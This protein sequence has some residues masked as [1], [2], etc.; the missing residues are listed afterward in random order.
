MDVDLEQLL[1]IEQ[2]AFEQRLALEFQ[3]LS[4]ALE[5]SSSSDL[6]RSNLD[7]MLSEVVFDH[8]LFVKVCNLEAHFVNK[9][10]EHIEFFGGN[11]TGVEV[12]R[13]T[14][15]DRDKLFHDVLGVDEN[16]LRDRLYALRDAHGRH[17]INQEWQVTKDVFNIA[18]LWLIHG[19]IRSSSLDAKLRYEAQIRLGCY[20]YYKFLTSLLAHYFKY[21]ADRQVAQATYESLTLKFALKQFGSWWQTIRDLSEKTLGSESPYR[22]DLERMDDD[23]RVLYIIA[24]LQGRIRDMLKNIYKEFLRVHSSG[25]KIVSTSALVESD[26]EMVLRDNTKN[27]GVYAR[28][29]KSIIADKNTFIRPEL[30]DV[31]AS[32]MHTLSRRL[33]QQSLEWTSDNYL[34]QQSRQIEEAVDIVLEH[35]IEYMSLNRTVQRADLANLI[36]KLRGAYMSSR[37]TDP[38]LILA[39]QA[40]GELVK[41]ATGSRNESMVATVRTSWM[42]YVVS[43][44]FSMHFYATR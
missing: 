23:A 32:V 27:P 33:L 35:A 19:F 28:Y 12:V 41:S 10:R 17:V 7:D 29:L 18:C 43:R 8:K 39:R 42:L 30:M 26:G 36:D 34:S 25:Q 9:K 40:I 31:I 21:P 5:A 38:K 24:N 11:L 37:S 14:S 6:L 3:Q 15:A 16:D 13:F 1:D 44:A 2:S 22:R 4:L 20:L